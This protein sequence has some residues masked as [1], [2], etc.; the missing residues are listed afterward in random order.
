[1]AFH[2]A[3]LTWFDLRMVLLDRKLRVQF[4][5]IDEVEY[6]WLVAWQAWAC[7]CWWGFEI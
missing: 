5:W 3:L 7:W 4:S 2:I 1:M 6:R